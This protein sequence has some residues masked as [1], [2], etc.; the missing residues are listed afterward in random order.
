MLLSFCKVCGDTDPVSLLVVCVSILPPE[1]F[2]RGQEGGSR[3]LVRAADS[4]SFHMMRKIDFFR[5]KG[6]IPVKRQKTN[7]GFS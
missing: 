3:L 7:L 6:F 5:A 1:I 2:D 4:I